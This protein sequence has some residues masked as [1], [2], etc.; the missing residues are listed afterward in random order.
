MAQPELREPT[1]SFLFW[2]PKYLKHTQNMFISTFTK[3]LKNRRKKYLNVNLTCRVLWTPGGWSPSCC[4]PPACSCC[5]CNAST[6]P[7]RPCSSMSTIPIQ[8]SITDC[9]PG[10]GVE[11]VLAVLV[12]VVEVVA[13]HEARTLVLC[14]S[15]E[16]NQYYTFAFL[17]NTKF[18]FKT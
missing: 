8:P 17:I 9:G 6:S 5:G 16:E 4:G 3:Y 12:P 2:V 1:K 18:A 13:R 14:S 15:T 7:S 11:V 10:D